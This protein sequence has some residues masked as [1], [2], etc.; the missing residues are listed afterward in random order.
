M[1]VLIQSRFLRS[2]TASG[3]GVI[4]PT[5]LAV[6]GVEVVINWCQVV[7]VEQMPPSCFLLK[8]GAV[9]LDKPFRATAK[10]R[11]NSKSRH[12]VEIVVIRCQGLMMLYSENLRYG[13]S[14]LPGEPKTE[15][16]YS[17]GFKR[18]A[19]QPTSNRSRNL[20]AGGH[21]GVVRRPTTSDLP[22]T[23]CTAALIAFPS[24]LKL[25]V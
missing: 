14:Q 1:K 21:D 4:R 7:L 11:K 6:Y 20:L 17:D 22:T 12:H 3:I 15:R 10:W 24:I 9:Y 13:R 18:T 2:L 19:S 16:K 8:H 23:S 25:P 5:V